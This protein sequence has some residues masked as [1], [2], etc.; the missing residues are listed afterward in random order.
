VGLW[1]GNTPKGQKAMDFDVVVSHCSGDLAWLKRKL[2][3]LGKSFS[4]RSIVI[5]SKCGKHVTGAPGQ[6]TVVRL[7]NVG[8]CDHTY[9]KYMVDR[10][11]NASERAKASNVVLFIKDTTWL[12]QG[13]SV[14]TPLADVVSMAAGPSGFGCGVT[15]VT[16]N[17]LESSLN[18]V[19][20]TLNDGITCSLNFSL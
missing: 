17:R 5:F 1:A 12:H 11:S 6:A 14:E 19:G 10:C 16:P 13:Q 15:M 18:H 3:V 4:M 8:R 20:T 9:A 2:A 7:P